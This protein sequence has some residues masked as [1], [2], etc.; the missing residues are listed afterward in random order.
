MNNSFEIQSLIGREILDSRGNP[1]VEVECELRDGASA[2]AAVPSGASTGSREAVELRDGDARRFRGKG[3]LQAVANVNEIIAPGLQGLDARQQA[4]IDHAM[5]ELDGTPNKAR[6]GANA[7]LGVSLAVARAAAA[8]SR[9]PL[10]QYLGGP[11]ATRLPVP[12]MN[13]LNGGVHAHWQGADFQEFMIAPYGADS[14]RQ[15]L[16]WG[17]EVYHALQALLEKKGL[18]VGVGDEGGFAPQVSSNQEPFDLIMRA[19]DD[20]GLIPGRDVGIA[21]DPA[22]SEFYEKG[23]YHLRSEKRSL[24]SAAMTAYYAKLIDHYPLV[25]LEDGMAEDDWPGWKIHFAE[26]GGRIELVGDDVFCTNPAIIARGIEENIANAV[27]IKLNQIGTLTETITATR[28]ARNH[29]WGAFVSH[30]SGETVDS[31]IADMTVALDTGHL[32]TGAPARGE[33]VEK[34]NQLLRIEQ[35]LGTAASYAGVGAYVHPPRRA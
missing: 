18:S 34:Y 25:L 5:I 14:F 35:Q 10:Y 3:V 27:L 16:E 8:A 21:C 30:R 31:F 33:R 29:G 28:L 15:A 11:G 1:T 12:H 17:S 24:D 26:L 13:I 6:L 7:I 32:K 22:S 19:I 2:R 20:A 23:K 4:I 9:L